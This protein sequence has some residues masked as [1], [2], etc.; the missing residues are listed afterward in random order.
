MSANILNATTAQVS[1]S[2]VQPFPYRHKT[3]F[4]NPPQSKAEKVGGLRSQCQIWRT[5]RFHLLIFLWPAP[6]W[7]PIAIDL[8]HSTLSQLLTFLLQPVFLSCCFII[9]P[10][11]YF[12]FPPGFLPGSTSKS[13]IS[14]LNTGL[15]YML[16]LHIFLSPHSHS[17]GVNIIA[18]YFTMRQQASVWQTLKFGQMC[19]DWSDVNRK[20]FFYFH[21]KGFCAKVICTSHVLADILFDLNTVS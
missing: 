6:S 14:W 8:S 21:I 10:L 9:T 4:W 20:F 5:N 19:L 2:L 18:C 11:F 1:L 15:W 16:S 13:S 7:V 12:C 3:S 17:H